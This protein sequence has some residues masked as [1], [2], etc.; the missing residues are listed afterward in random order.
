MFCKIILVVN[1]VKCKA[2]YMHYQA[3]E[4]HASNNHLLALNKR[5]ILINF[6]LF[7]EKWRFLAFTPISRESREFPVLANPVPG[8]PVLEKVGKTQTLRMTDRMVIGQFIFLGNSP[9]GAFGASRL[10]LRR[11]GA[12]KIS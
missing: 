10:G 7:I 9:D 6:D 3:H 11:W 2:A 8:V 4:R 12:Q 1:A 5:R